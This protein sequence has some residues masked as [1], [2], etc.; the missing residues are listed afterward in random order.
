[1]TWMILFA[2]LIVVGAMSLSSQRQVPWAS[3]LRRVNAGVARRAEWMAPRHIVHAVKVDYRR[4]SRWLS[5]SAL[6]PWADQWAAAPDYLS[7]SFLKRHQEILKHHRTGYPPRY[8]GIFR[9]MRAIEVHQFSADG[10]RC[11]IVDHQADQHMITYDYWT[12]TQLA[13]Q[14]LGSASLVYEMRYDR[15]DARWKID[16]YVQQLPVG[17]QVGGASSRRLRL[18]SDLPATVGRDQ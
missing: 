11:L 10:E 15:Q 4:A 7:G 1:M 9:C 3:G 12:Q 2:F 8:T 14:D 18:F 5:D 13:T 6:L 16:R 17:W